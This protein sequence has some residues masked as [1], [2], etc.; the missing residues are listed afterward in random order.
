MTL[1]V[2]VLIL[3]LIKEILDIINQLLGLRDKLSKESKGKTSPD[4]DDNGP[5]ATAMPKP[6]AENAQE[7]D[8]PKAA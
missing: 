8:K 6:T 5:S 7:Q 3:A 2:V 1:A 4:P